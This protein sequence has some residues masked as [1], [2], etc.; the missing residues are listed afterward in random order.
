MFKVERYITV[1]WDPPGIYLL[2]GMDV[3]MLQSWEINDD[4]GLVV[5]IGHD[6]LDVL[7]VEGWS[8]VS[9]VVPFNVPG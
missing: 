7:D 5:S 6:E 1:V 2:L 9:D 8:I 4:L 3:E